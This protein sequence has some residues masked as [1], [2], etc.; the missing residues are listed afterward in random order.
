MVGGDGSD[1]I[2]GGAGRNVLIGGRGGDAITG[3]SD[4]DLLIAGFTAFDNNVP[5]LRSIMAEW[6]SA[7]P[8]ATRVGHLQG[9]I[10]GGLNSV[11]L[12]AG[13]DPQVP[14]GGINPDPRSVFDDGVRDVL[15]GAEGSDWFFFS[16][17]D[18]TDIVAGEFG[19]DTGDGTI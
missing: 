2:S 7:A 6:A 16:P 8:I 17:N 4:E 13:P 10:Q 14:P 5:A 9:T 1:T 3:G 19:T 12:I 18:D 11:F 15:T